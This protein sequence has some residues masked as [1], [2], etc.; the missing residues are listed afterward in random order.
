MKLK[1]SIIIGFTCITLFAQAQGTKATPLEKPNVLFIVV[2]DL[3]DYLSLLANYPGVK[4]PNLDRFAETAINFKRSY[5]AAPLCNP[6]RAAFLSGIQPARSGVYENEDQ[7]TR[8][9]AIEDAVLLPEQFKRNGYHTMWNGKLFHKIPSAQRHNA[10]W[11]DTEGGQGTYGPNP[12]VNPWAPIVKGGMFSSEAWTGPDNDFC[13]VTNMQ[14]NANRLSKTY[15]KPFFLAYGIY[16]PHN[17]WTAPKRFFDMHPLE[18]I[19]LP[20]VPLDDLD[21]VPAI[22]REWAAGSVSMRKMEKAGHWKS[23]VQSYLA[24][25]S[26]MDDN[27]GKVLDALEKGPNADNT[28]VCLIGDNGF[29]LG[30]KE[31]FTKFALWEQATH[32]MQLWRVPGVTTPGSICSATVNLLDL[33]PTFNELCGLSSVPQQLDG[34]SLVPLLTNPDSAWDRPSV[35]TYRQNNYAA[36][37]N[38]W[39]Y[40]RYNDGTEELYDHDNDPKEWTNLA[41]QTEYDVVKSR[42]AQYFPKE[43]VASVGK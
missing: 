33:Y 34:T 8:S 29:H 25:I 22:G 28:I 41:G 27:L 23:L 26:F 38:R 11:D 12:D 20:N 36:R 7:L 42:L 37:D 1:L 31:H 18:D 32:V 19:Q 14:I 30:E 39:R 16:R 9:R 2:D 35:M 17:P 6:S 3:N 24:C 43:S 10:M 5:A 4:T 15:T 40:I 21:D 13:D